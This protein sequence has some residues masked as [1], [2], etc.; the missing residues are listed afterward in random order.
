MTSPLIPIT[1]IGSDWRVPG[2]TAEILFAQGPASASAGQREVCLVMPMIQANT[3]CSGTWTPATLYKVDSEKAASDGA[4]PGSPLHIAAK[5]FLEANKNAKL[6]ALP[7]AESS[8]G[9][10]VAGTWVLTITAAATNPTATGT[11]IVTVCGEDCSYTFTTADTVTTI[12]A[13][14]KA[15]INAKTWL[16]VVSDNSS[17]VL[18]VTAKLKGLSQGDG[19]L[20]PIRCRSSVTAGLG[21]TL[22]NTGAGIGV[23]S[24]AAVA[25]ADGS[26]TEAATTAT[27]LAN[28]AATKK[29]YLVTSSQLNTTLGSFKTHLA[30]KAEPRQGMR[31]EL[32]AGY[33]HTLA[34]CQTLATGLNYEREQIAW[35]KNSDWTPAQIAANL[36][37]IRQKREQTDSAANHAGYSGPDWLVPAA[38]STADWPDADDQ[39]DAIND[40]ITPIASKDGG[41]SFIVM[42]VNTRSKNS[43]GTLDDFRACETHRVSVADEFVD[44]MCNNAVL[45]HQGKKF[46]DDEYLADGSVNPN[47]RFIRGVLTPSQYKVDVIKQLNEYEAAAKLQEVQASKD[48]LR[49]VKSPANASRCE[50]GLDLHVIDHAHQFTFRVAE[51]SVG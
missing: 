19:T 18:T 38:Y 29:Y 30:T 13:G 14:L 40:G 50:V 5:V 12:A 42:S 34:A 26:T 35:Q 11:A 31:S 46:K 45:N 10:P 28:I 7:V 47:Q 4:G 15:A 48:G 6:W 27:A 49:V 37:A 33:T 3:T 17:G 1:G 43:T 22:A 41:G 20:I 8:G 44:E 9:S 24:G 2:A 36:A 51:V 23:V 16:P 21:I 32:C 39:N 25:G